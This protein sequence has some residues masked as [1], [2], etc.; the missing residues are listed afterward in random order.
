MAKFPQVKSGKGGKSSPSNTAE[1]N[2]TGPNSRIVPYQRT[3]I[4]GCNAQV[5]VGRKE[6]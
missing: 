4:Q 3:F 5:A 1:R 6:Y 2:L